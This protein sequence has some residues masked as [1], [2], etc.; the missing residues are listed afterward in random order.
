VS[1]VSPPR[2]RPKTSV[3]NN[4]VGL[5]ILSSVVTTG[6]SF[7]TWLYFDLIYG[8]GRASWNSGFF[9]G[10]GI[11]ETDLCSVLSGVLASAV[12]ALVCAVVLRFRASRLKPDDPERRAWLWTLL[13]GTAVPLLALFAIVWS[14]RCR[15][16]TCL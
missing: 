5:T 9:A 14:M 4:L 13:V 12:P 6:M 11:P 8:A 1:Y 7:L 3:G 2:A 16:W 15:W 10:G